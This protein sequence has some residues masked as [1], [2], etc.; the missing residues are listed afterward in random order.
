VLANKPSILIVD[1]V[2]ANLVAL[3]GV[4]D[5]VP[6]NIVRARGGNDALREL[7][8]QEFAVML[9]DVQ[10]PEMD[11]FEVAKYA[12][13]D[14]MTRDVPIIFL[15]A[16]HD[17]EA[18]ILR[19]YGSGA[20]DF[21]LKPLNPH[22]L[23]AK[24]RV[25]LDLYNSRHKL[26]AEV[27]AHRVTLASLELA[28][29]ALRHFA[30]AASHDLKAP[31]R[32]M[33]GF[34]DALAVEVGSTLPAHAVDYLERSRLASQR[35][36]SLLNALR[37]YA[38]LQ[39]PIANV[40]VDTNQ[41]VRNVLGDL[42]DRIESAGASVEVSE[43]PPVQADPDR[44]YQLLL[45][46]IAN[47]VKF[48]RPGVPPRIK[49]YVPAQARP[50]TLCVEDNGIGIEPRQYD[51]VFE[52]FIRLHEESKYEGTGL[53]LAICKQI[54]HQHGGSLWVES[55]PRRG[56]RF[57]FTLGHPRDGARGEPTAT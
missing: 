6:C 26:A 43:L 40:M 45:N 44:L 19:G 39:R 41:V 11:G 32:A 47:A 15:T 23:R 22:V 9:L 38:G 16:M 48:S 49:V 55:E 42:K 21:L 29:T 17:S 54:V 31:L 12:R 4:L 53:G 1:D 56:S 24:V 18:S 28:N 8:K 30:Q 51:A 5:D 14:P 35:M 36:D 2:E 37:T 52:A 34:L 50:F 3:E 46:L 33:R 57:Y 10:M 25:F 13:G 20:V 27:A 7:L